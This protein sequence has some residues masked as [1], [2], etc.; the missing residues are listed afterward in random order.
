[1]RSDKK[2]IWERANFVEKNRLPYRAYNCTEPLH[3]Y[4]SCPKRNRNCFSAMF[5]YFTFPSLILIHFSFVSAS[6]F[7]FTIR[8]NQEEHVVGR[9]AFAAYY[10]SLRGTREDGK[11]WRR[12]TEGMFQVQNVLVYADLRMCIC[13]RNREKAKHARKRC[14][15]REDLDI[16][17]PLPVCRKKKAHVYTCKGNAYC[18][19]SWKK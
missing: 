10:I 14:K 5:F 15:R 12:N 9:I 13:N 18:N 1:M 8:I 19:V 11:N 16:I 7:H 6:L 2:L 3:V 4:I 17:F